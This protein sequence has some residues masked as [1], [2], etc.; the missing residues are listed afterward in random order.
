MFAIQKCIKSCLC[1]EKVIGNKK[2]VRGVV[3]AT[4]TPVINK[5]AEIM[6]LVEP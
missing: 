1:I 3:M 2:W 4:V 6:K 5:H